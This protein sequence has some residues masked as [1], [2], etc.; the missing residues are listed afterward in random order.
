[1]AAAGGCWR[2]AELVGEVTAKEILLAGRVLTAQEAHDVRLLNEVVDAGDLMTTAHQWIDR[3]L[4][5]APLALRLTKLAITAPRSAHPSIDNIAQAVLFETDE[6]RD[7]MTAF[8]EK[9]PQ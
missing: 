4:K 9:R 5:S 1:M 7:R 3:I 8:L 2:L 6:K